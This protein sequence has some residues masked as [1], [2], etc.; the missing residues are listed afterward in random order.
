MAM[1]NPIASTVAG[2]TGTQS[3]SDESL[4]ADLDTYQELEGY[5]LVDGSVTVEYDNGTGYQTATEGTDYDLALENGTV[6]P[7]S[8]GSIDQGDPLRVTYDYQVT[9][10]TTTTIVRLIPLFTALMVLGL[11][12]FKVQQ[13]M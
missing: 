9:D 11:F 3:I 2:N 12:A 4:S 7:L 10:G 13:G 8:S 5:N 1:F 6:K